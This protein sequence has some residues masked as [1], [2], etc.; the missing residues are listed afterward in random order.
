MWRKGLLT[1]R[2]GLS[3]VAEKNNEEKRR[4]H[5]LLSS[6]RLHIIVPMGKDARRVR[7][8]EDRNFLWTQL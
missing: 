7:G 1:V 3:V 4:Y 8:R 5:L 2:R 6:R